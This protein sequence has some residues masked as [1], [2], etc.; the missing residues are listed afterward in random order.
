MWKVRDGEFAAEDGVL[1]QYRH[2]PSQNPSDR[3][4]LLFH[5]G[6]EHS[7]RWTETVERLGMPELHV[8]AWDAR[9][10][11]RSPGRR[12][13]A[14]SFA[15]YVRDAEAFARHVE[16]AHGVPLANMVALGNSVGAVI[17]AAWTHDY[18]PP[19]VGAISAP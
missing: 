1:L 18:A 14:E 4:L 3:A 19:I 9:G 17:A 6:H 15:A 10:H 12:G 11:G 8:F 7:A 16:S 13:H 5:R 2:W